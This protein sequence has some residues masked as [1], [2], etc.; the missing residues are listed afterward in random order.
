MRACCAVA[1]PRSPREDARALF[2]L[3]LIIMQDSNVEWGE[4]QS[5]QIPEASSGCE[6]IDS[7]LP[8]FTLGQQGC[9]VVLQ[10]SE[11]V[12]RLT[13]HSSCCSSK[14][15]ARTLL[16]FV[17]SVGH[18]KR[19]ASLG[20]PLLSRPCRAVGLMLQPFDRATTCSC[21]ISSRSS[22]L[23]ERLQLDVVSKRWQRLA[24]AEL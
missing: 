3:L 13:T 17:Y 10:Q 5:N 15:R 8:L 11:V 16:Y 22:L 1:C 12:R 14:P 24:S 6:R 23:E 4:V 19:S 2:V 21:A 20:S 7:A 9:A 18:L